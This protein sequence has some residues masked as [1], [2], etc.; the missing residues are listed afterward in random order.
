MSAATRGELVRLTHLLT[1]SINH[2][3]RPAL[4]E[5]LRTLVASGVRPVGP[6][7]TNALG[8]TFA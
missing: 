7:R 3:N 2:P 8:M 6:F 5:H 1:Q 4:E